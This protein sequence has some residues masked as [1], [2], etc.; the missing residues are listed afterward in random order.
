MFV[1]SIVAAAQN[2]CTITGSVTDTKGESISYASAVLY[3]EGKIL[4]GGVT[5]DKGRFSLAVDS[6]SKDSAIDVLS[7]ASSVTIAN[8][9]ISIRGN[10]NILVLIDGIPT[11]VSDLSAI[12]ANHS[13]CLQT[14]I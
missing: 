13:S 12:P 4:T 14:P 3:G 9:V 11:T 2:K 7:S 6:S 1:W 5:D 8:D 10:S